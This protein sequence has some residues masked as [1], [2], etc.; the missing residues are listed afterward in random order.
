MQLVRNGE[1]FNLHKTVWFEGYLQLAD[2]VTNNIREDDLNPRLVYYML[3]LDNLQNT[4]TILMIGYRR[5]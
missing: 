1:K 2:I 4:C 3:R 5:V